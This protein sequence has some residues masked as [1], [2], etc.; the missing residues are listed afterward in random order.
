MK[1]YPKFIV[2]LIFLH[3]LFPESI[4]AQI[5]VKLGTTVSNFYYSDNLSPK[6]DYDTDLRPYLGYDIEFAQLSSQKPIIS[7]YLS[8]YYTFQ[9]SSRFGLQPELSFTQKGVNFS[10]SDYEK[11]IYKV[12]ISYIEIPLSFFYQFI[13]KE[14]SISEL[15]FG[16]YGAFKIRAIKEVAAHNTSTEKK[17]VNNVNAFEGGLHFGANYKHKFCENFF[18]IDFR[19][20]I[21]LSDIFSMPDDWTSIYFDTQKTKTTGFN[22]TLGYEF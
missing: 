2:Y 14:K 15:Y 17:H 16:G 19:I 13:Q 4:R 10:H 11:I 18:L 7:P 12:R 3:I 5:G 8:A 9:L 6:F 1:L 20:F 21:G 22:L